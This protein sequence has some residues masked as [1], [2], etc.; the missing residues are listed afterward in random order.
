VLRMDGDMY[1]STMEALEALYP[2]LS[3][4]GYV[5]VDDYGAI[6]QCRHAVHDYRDAHGI[7][8]EMTTVDWTGVH[9]K[10]SF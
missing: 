4:G 7:T 6:E 9:W 8:D 1:Q 3:V 2:K 10:R 5:I